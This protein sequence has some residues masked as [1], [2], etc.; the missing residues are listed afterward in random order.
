V[1]RGIEEKDRNCSKEERGVRAE[2]ENDSERRLLCGEE[3][4]AGY[5]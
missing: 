5:L 4:V 3:D 2:R 1:G